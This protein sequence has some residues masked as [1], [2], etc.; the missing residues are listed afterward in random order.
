MYLSDDNDPVPG[1]WA[2]SSPGA[3][4]SRRIVDTA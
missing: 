4:L 1:R 3:R 2:V